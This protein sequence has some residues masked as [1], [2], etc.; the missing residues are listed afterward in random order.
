MILKWIIITGLV[1]FSLA[2]FM[3][4]AY[5]QTLLL[6]LIATSIVF[7]PK[8]IERK[9]DR[10][11]SLISRIVF[12]LLLIIIKVV[13]LGGE[14]KTSIYTS[15][16]NRKILTNIYDQKVKDWPV[17]TEDIFIV[18]SYGKV[19]VLAC[20]AKENP[21]ILLFHAASMGA[22]SWAENLPP[23]LD[24]YRIYAIDNIGEGNKSALID[25]TVYP[26]SPKEIANF[27]ALIADSLG[28]KSSP[29][30]GASN[31]GY[32]A[33]VYAYYYPEKVESLALFGPM[34]LTQLT[35]NSILMLGLTSMYPLQPL[36]DRVSKWAIGDN[37]Y[38]NQKYGDWFNQIMI[39]TI[40]SVSMPIPMTTEQK[41][42]M[43]L[44]ILLFL[45]TKDPIVGDAEIAKQTARDY[46]NI[47][48][49]ILK[50][51]HLISVEHAETINEKVSKFLT[52]ES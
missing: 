29:V 52:I 46:P 8:T 21:P 16:E 15:E 31:G 1:L 11:A 42:Q 39:S 9:W 38:V 34:G 47:Q 14:P 18:T 43:D 4:G 40:P 32:I 41:K 6:L 37:Q 33:Q 51:G 20:G 5:A 12:L 17:E 36:R 19:H 10:K 2:T 13:F 49:E 30:F 45:G 44:P 35:G 24:H 50:S 22:H 27:Y 23:L 25:A 7:W 28:I 3:G 26:N 48:I